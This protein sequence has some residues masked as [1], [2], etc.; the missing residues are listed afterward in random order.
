MKISRCCIYI[1]GF[2]LFGCSPTYTLQL[3]EEKVIGIQ[4]E[5]DSSI[6]A[7][8]SPYQKGIEAQMNEVLAYSKNN[9]EKGRPQSTIGNFVTDLCLNYAD[10]H[11]CVMNNGGLRTTLEKGEITRGDIYKLMPFENELVVLELNKTD[12]IRLLNYIIKRG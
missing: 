10:A 6:M 2:A 1:I 4:A 9:L 5:N 3:H 8:I 12:F 7:I 11:I